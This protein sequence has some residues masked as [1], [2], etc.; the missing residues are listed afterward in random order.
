MHRLVRAV[1]CCFQAS[2]A[3]L[4][5]GVVVLLPELLPDPVPALPEGVGLD[6]LP[7]ALEPEPW[8]LR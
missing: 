3:Y 7:V 8:P 2:C 5:G 6:P 1:H 4:V